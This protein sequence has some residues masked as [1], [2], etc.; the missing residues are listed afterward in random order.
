MAVDN[1]HTKYLKGRDKRAWEGYKQ[2]L[3]SQEKLENFIE[4]FHVPHLEEGEEYD[5][6]IRPKDKGQ[7][8]TK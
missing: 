4:G 7:K 8:T 1:T 3:V 2:A 6:P 5:I